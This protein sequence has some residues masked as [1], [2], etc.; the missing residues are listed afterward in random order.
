MQVQDYNGTNISLTCFPELTMFYKIIREIN[1]TNNANLLLL[2]DNNKNKFV[3]KQLYTLDRYDIYNINAYSSLSKYPNRSPFLTYYGLFSLENRPVIVMDYFEGN[4]FCDLLKYQKLND[5]QGLNENVILYMILRIS[6]SLIYL[7]ERNLVHSDLNCGNVLYKDDII[8]LIDMHPAYILN[9]LSE[10][11]IP[12]SSEIYKTL[13]KDKLSLYKK[14]D[15]FH[16][17]MLIRQI[18]TGMFESLEFDGDEDYTVYFPK[19]PMIEYIINMC[20]DIN[21]NKR[22]TAL[23]IANIAKRYLGGSTP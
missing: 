19:Y 6:E 12:T 22:P 4:T 9:P 5:F 16:L 21:P 1:R 11:L 10:E 2:E 23:E 13:E 15:I 17:G 20:V 8:K 14:F 18:M 7:H 3:G